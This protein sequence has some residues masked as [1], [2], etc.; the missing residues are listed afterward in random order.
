MCSWVPNEVVEPAVLIATPERVV[1]VVPNANGGE[2]VVAAQA[3]L[4]DDSVEVFD[5][6]A[7]LLDVVALRTD[8]ACCT[9]WDLISRTEALTVRVLKPGMRRRRRG[10][11]PSCLWGKDGTRTA[12]AAARTVRAIV[13]TA[14][15][16]AGC[17]AEEGR[18][19]TGRTFA[20]PIVAAQPKLRRERA[21]GVDARRG[22]EGQREEG[23]EGDPSSSEQRDLQRASFTPRNHRS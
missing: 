8:R 4:V 12:T 23:D 11:V 6:T 3:L 18:R 20:S 13:V 19:H 14:G 10:E 17:A 1:E 5:V 22:H 16:F 7:P 2:E 15:G 9:A 21:R